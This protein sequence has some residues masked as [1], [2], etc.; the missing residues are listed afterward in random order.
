MTLRARI[1][2]LI[3]ASSLLPALAMLWVLWENRTEAVLRAQD[4]LTNLAESIAKDLD[5]RVNGTAQLLFGLGR[6]HLVGSNDAATCS[7]FLADVLNE[8]PQY[9]GLLT[10][11]PDGQLHCDSLRSG[12]VLNLTDRG[13]FKRALNSTRFVV[14]PVIGRLTGKGVL[15]IAHPVRDSA[16]ALQ[17]VLLAS[18]NLDDFGKSVASSLP[19]DQMNFQIWNDDGSII[20]DYAGTRAT[21]LQPG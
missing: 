10:I 20:M 1:L 5:D 18:L 2:A 6:V 15:Q 4:Q 17:Y 11:L 8:H 21:S 9:T 19:Y 12:R 14:E 3:L 16:G 7:A 13:Y